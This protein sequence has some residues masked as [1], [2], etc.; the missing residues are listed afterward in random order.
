MNAWT[1]YGW[2]QPGG[3]QVVTGGPF[4]V[5]DEAALV[6]GVPVCVDPG[7]ASNSATTTARNASLTTDP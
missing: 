2:T 1:P 7:A 6:H 3:Y 4:I 5:I